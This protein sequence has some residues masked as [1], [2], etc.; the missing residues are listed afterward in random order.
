[1]K[2]ITVILLGLLVMS[3][4]PKKEKLPFLGNPTVNGNETK[5]PKVSA[6]SFLDQN[7]TVV[8]N[9][10]FD[11]KIYIADFIFLSC[12]TICPKMNVEM[13]KVYDV[14]KDNTEVSFLSHT[15][16]PKN[17]TTEKLKEYAKA[18]KIDDSKWHFVNGNRDSIY[19]IATKSYFTTAYPDAKEPGG[20]V[21]GGGLLL[22]DKNRHIRGVYDGT[23]PKETKRLIND[24]QILLQE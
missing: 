15:I 3:C 9:K 5:Y 23:D 16:D 4:S 13:K 17:D 7:N 12:P 1:M 14:Y 10:T 8:T 6:F 22:V 24:L 19:S 2:K 18:L 21:H 11:N 20:F